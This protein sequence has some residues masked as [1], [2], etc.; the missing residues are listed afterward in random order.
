MANAAVFTHY[1]LA[2]RYTQRP[3]PSADELRARGFLAP[4]GSVVGGRLYYMWYA[5]DYD[6]AAWLYS[7]LLARWNDPVRGGVSIG[8][9]VD[10]ELALRFPPIF[11]LLLDPQ[12]SAASDVLISGDSGAGYVNPT[13]LYGPD[14][15]RLSGLPDGVSLWQRWNTDWNRQFGISFTGFAITGFA[16]HMDAQAEAMYVNFSAGGLVNQGWPGLATHL[17]ANMPVFVQSD[18]PSDVGD[19]A[20]AIAAKF[21]ASQR[22]PQFWMFRSVLTSPSFLK[23]VTDAAAARTGGGAIAVDPLTLGTLARVALGGSLDNRVSYTADTLPDAAPPGA[24]LP[25]TVT[26]RNDGWNAL[27]ADGHALLVSVTSVQALHRRMHVLEPRRRQRAAAERASARQQL[28]EEGTGVTAADSVTGAA[29][30]PAA[31]ALLRPLRRPGSR[32]QRWLDRAEYAGQQLINVHAATGTATAAVRDLLRGVTFPLP[33]DLSVSGSVT[34]PASLI[35]PLL[36]DFERR[37]MAGE[38][39]ERAPLLITVTYQLCSRTGTGRAC[40]T[41]FDA[42]G[43]IAW[44]HDILVQ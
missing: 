10:P 16:P 11:P 39:G 25:F 41:T 5:G 37:P 14:R 18:V 20:A 7:Q 12:Q 44:V 9:A 36:R 8:W 6:S 33:A 31:A 42:L 40:N 24:V 3:P 2:D 28:G 29:D 38:E 13:A 26:I 22:A 15:A 30:A 27:R 1:P 35:V 32:L 19:A 34:V 23:N 4:N 43:N 21:N 17:T